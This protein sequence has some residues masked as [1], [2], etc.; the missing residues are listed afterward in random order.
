MS[1]ATSLFETI[2]GLR[3]VRRFKPDPIEEDKI[4]KILRAATMAP[5]A[6]NAQPWRFIVVRGHE[7]KAKIRKIA[8]KAWHQLMRYLHPPL[9]RN[10]NEGRRMVENTDKVP[11]LIFVFGDP[12]PFLEQAKRLARIALSLRVPQAWRQLNLNLSASVYP[13]VQ[14]ILLSAKGLGLGACLTTSIILREKEVK[15]VLKV[16]KAL[17]L[18]SLIY[19]GYPA[20]ALKPPVRRP[21]VEFIHHDGWH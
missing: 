10:F 8:L 9:A 15:Q 18:F 17:R 4:S 7:T 16:P 1:E 14:N 19:L 13:A 2:H 3:A 11:V 12:T 21:V 20:V 5:N 6:S